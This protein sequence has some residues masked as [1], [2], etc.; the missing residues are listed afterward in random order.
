MLLLSVIVPVYNDEKYI[1]NTLYS[2]YNQSLNKNNYEVI[3][4]NDGSTD[5]TF[6][7]CE[8]FLEQH[9]EMNISLYSQV[10]MGV[11][12]ARNKGLKIAGAKYVAFIDGDDILDDHYFEEAITKFQE[13]KI[14]NLVTCLR[15]ANIKCLGYDKNEG[16]VIKSCSD[17]YNFMLSNT[18]IYSGY[19]TNKL[20]DLDII[21][22]NNLF[23]D[24]EISYWE[25][26]L[27]IE[28]Y[29]C[30]CKGKALFLNKYYY[31]YRV[32]NDSATFTTNTTRIAK[33]IYSKALAVVCIFKIAN[34]DSELYWQ[35]L[36]IYY[37]LLIE[38]KILCYKGLISQDAFMSLYIKMGVSMKEALRQVSLKKRF[39]FY[40]SKAFNKL[41]KY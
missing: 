18:T 35:S 40:I 1:S 39:K 19:I 31:Y 13:N 36:H 41:H 5:N 28:R 8:K 22:S 11:S 6:E 23:F 15:T 26:M 29:L 27:F 12:A 14:I 30:K 3:I 25:D 16:N 21:K 20:F 10:N 17:M 2:I 38:C 32:N 34:K 33:N 9:K 7:I 4:I 24:E 37:N